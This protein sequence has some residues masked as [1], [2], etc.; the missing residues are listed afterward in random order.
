MLHMVMSAAPDTWL[1]VK[2]V[3]TAY[4]VDGKDERLIRILE[5]TYSDV[6]SMCLQVRFRFGLH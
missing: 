1:E 6:D 4:M 5:D 3:L 2:R